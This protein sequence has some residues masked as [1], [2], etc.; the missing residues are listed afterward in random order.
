M[1]VLRNAQVCVIDDDPAE[2][3][4]LLRVLNTFGFGCVHV[5][6][7]KAEE[8]PDTPFDNIRLVFLDMHLGVLASHDARA[9]TAQTARVF[10]RVVKPN[11]AP[12]VVILWTK[13][14]SYLEDF[15][16]SLFEAQSDFRGK[17]FFLK[18][19][20]PPKAAEI[21]EAL[22]STS[23]KGQLEAY[24]PLALLWN[25]DTLVSRAACEVTS[26]LCR[27]AAFQ[28]NLT[29][30]DDEQ[31][32]K[33]KMLPALKSV[34]CTLLKADA[35]KS[36]TEENASQ[37]LLNV[38]GPL[39]F[40]R[41]ENSYSQSELDCSYL[42]PL[43]PPGMTEEMKVAF[44]TMLLVGNVSE[45]RQSFV[46]G[47]IYSITNEEGFEE[48]L[49]LSFTEIAK[50]FCQSDLLASGKKT[51]LKEWVAKCHPILI[52][53]SPAC[54]FAQQK[55][56]V[57]RL[58]VGLLVP[59]TAT[60]GF[61]KPKNEGYSAIRG[62]EYVNIPTIAGSHIPYFSSSL[63]LS[64]PESKAHDFL[65]SLARLRE[66]AFTDLRNWLASQSARMGYLQIR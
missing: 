42:F 15:R 17:L 33:D 2:Y 1:K 52:E 21:D 20:K 57:A 28:A 58:V 51:E 35:D 22:L 8:L 19:D 39:H 46:P 64:W 29:T 40:D 55:R 38:L 31:Q 7:E 6:G 49:G 27:L 26:E 56:P 36:L 24:P 3:E 5:Q 47:T 41:L 10:S 50:Q 13:Y 16:K 12:I 59:E 60:K 11:S 30:A 65:K 62:M 18:L 63:V 44:H 48:A 53:V 25:W 4:P 45:G 37:A 54:D 14:S 32:E 61:K 66:P 23:I 9:V 34:L 43:P